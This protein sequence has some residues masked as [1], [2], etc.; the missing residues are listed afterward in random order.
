MRDFFIILDESESY[1]CE[2]ICGFDWCFR[3]VRSG[4]FFIDIEML[5]YVFFLDVY[6]YFYEI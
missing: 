3:N 5:L 6:W 4:L 2:E 1:L